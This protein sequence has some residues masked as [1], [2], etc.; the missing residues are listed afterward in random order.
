MLAVETAVYRFCPKFKDQLR[1]FQC[2]TVTDNFYSL[3]VAVD[4]ILLYRN[5]YTLAVKFQQ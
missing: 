4:H 5:I 3:V 1:N 2:R